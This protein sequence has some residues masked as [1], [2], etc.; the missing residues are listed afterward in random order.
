MGALF[1]DRLAVTWNIRLQE[2]ESELE[3]QFHT[4]KD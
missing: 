4:R 2:A 1:Q 3:N